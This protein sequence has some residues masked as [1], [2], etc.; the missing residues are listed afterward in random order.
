MVKLENDGSKA[1]IEIKGNTLDCKAELTYLID[2]VVREH[3]EFE[4]AILLGL[5]QNN[6]KEDLISKVK[7]ARNAIEIGSLMQKFEENN[8]KVAKKVDTNAE[9]CKNCNEKSKKTSEKLP[10]LFNIGKILEELVSGFDEKGD[11]NE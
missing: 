10:D 9:K 7:S 5:A 2:C 4:G 11:K 1:T 8:K 3:P 6:S